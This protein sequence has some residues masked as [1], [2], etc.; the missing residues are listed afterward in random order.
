[1]SETVHQQCPETDSQQSL[2]L[3]L[4]VFQDGHRW[5]RFRLAVG[6]TAYANG[7]GRS[8]QQSYAIL[9]PTATDWR[10]DNKVTRPRREPE[11]SGLRLRVPVS[12]PL[13]FE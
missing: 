5:A 1:V 7:D 12:L 13:S 11:P 3:R 9:P 8:A 2:A 6:P 10:P 4:Q